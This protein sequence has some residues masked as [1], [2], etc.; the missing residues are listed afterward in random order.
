M[1]CQTLGIACAPICALPSVAIVPPVPPVPVSGA[2]FGGGGLWL[3]K[4]QKPRRPLD[5]ATALILT[6]GDV[7]TAL[8][9]VR[10]GRNHEP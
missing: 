9:L 3:K 6:D 4:A 7:A 1:L 2:R 5:L 10:Q 8:V